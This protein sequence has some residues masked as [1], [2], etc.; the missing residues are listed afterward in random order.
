MLTLQVL[1]KDSGADNCKSP[2]MWVVRIQ[3]THA[4]LPEFSEIARAI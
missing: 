1:S 2:S 3:T 4:P